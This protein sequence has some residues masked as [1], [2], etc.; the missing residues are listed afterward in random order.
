MIWFNLRVQLIL[1]IN[2]HHILVVEQ[3]VKI[4]VWDL[5]SQENKIDWCKSTD[6]IL[7]TDRFLKISHLFDLMI[8]L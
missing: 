6:H 4:K 7:V 5:L 1:Q 2:K 8:G 3:I